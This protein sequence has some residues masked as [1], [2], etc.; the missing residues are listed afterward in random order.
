MFSPFKFIYEMDIFKQLKEKCVFIDKE[1]REIND[2]VKDLEDGAEVSPKSIYKFNENLKQLEKSVKGI[3]TELTK[4]IEDQQ[5]L[6]G[7]CKS[8]IRGVL[9]LTDN[10]QSEDSESVDD[11]STSTPTEDE[12]IENIA[13]IEEPKVPEENSSD[14]DSALTVLNKSLP[15]LL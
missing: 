4:D 11:S 13:P 10:L 12:D 2:K 7:E 3:I 9:C 8:V 1:I 6:L 14:I 15:R 5:Q